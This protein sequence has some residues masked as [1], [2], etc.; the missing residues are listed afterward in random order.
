MRILITGANGQL[1]KCLQEQAKSKENTYLFAS[2]D[3]LDITKE[4]DVMKFFNEN[5]IN[6]VINC[7]A[8]T[9]VDDANK[10]AMDAYRCNVIGPQNLAIA[11]KKYKATLI[12][13]SS[14]YIFDGTKNKPYKTNDEE[15]YWGINAYG[16]TKL[17]GEEVI[18]NVNCNSIIIRTSWL[19][20]EFGNNFL[21]TMYN[22]IKN[23]IETKVVNDQV[24]TPTYAQDLAI[25]LVDI[26]ENN[27]FKKHLNSVYHFT[28]EGVCS[29]YDFAKVIE[30]LMDKE[31]IIKPCT[32]QE[33]GNKT[34]RPSY[35]VLDK[36]IT[37][38]DFNITIPYWIDSVAKCLEILQNKDITQKE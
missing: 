26:I 34:P 2:H 7:A 28:N 5:D 32:T 12:H 11:C 6:I 29:W 23:G 16:Q 33:Y 14:D 24:G 35:S 8:Y 20:S 13:I 30:I 31:G 19:Y 22:R 4:D 3:I 18:H 21:K 17:E 37:K 1:G 25:F 10:E 36:T 15:F 27:S 9:K 38:A